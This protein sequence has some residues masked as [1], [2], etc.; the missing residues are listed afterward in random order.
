MTKKN[1][2]V[3][4]IDLT[5]PPHCLATCWE[6]LSAAEQAAA[7]RFHHQADRLR[8][9][10]RR[11]ARR[12][13]LGQRLGLDPGQVVFAQGPFG[14]PAV[15]TAPTQSLNFSTSSTHNLAVVAVTSACLGTPS[16]PGEPNAIEDPSGPARQVSNRSIGIDVEA[17]RGTA[18]DLAGVMQLLAPEEQSALERL[19]PDARI[20]AFYDCWTRK[21]ALLKA[22]GLGL[23]AALDQFAVTL[24]PDRPAS[25][26]RLSLP[27]S[28]VHDWSL[29]PLELGDALSATLAGP[30]GISVSYFDW[31]G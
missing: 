15:S 22:L 17:H 6:T 16:A 12:D 25:L 27:A 26:L 4:R 13:I 1:V 9:I 18:K 14:Q 8:F 24:E 7:N 5:R 19:L 21:E 30:V 11:A 3:W 2:E 31:P 23:S 10:V 29:I 20:V 28:S